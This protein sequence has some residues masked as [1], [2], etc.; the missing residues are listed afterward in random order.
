[1]T[2]TILCKGVVLVALLDDK[3]NDLRFQRLSSLNDML[4]VSL[5]PS[6]AG[7]L[8]ALLSNILVKYFDQVY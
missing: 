5:R 3:G 4:T 8:S 2:I 7:H 6:L 1:M